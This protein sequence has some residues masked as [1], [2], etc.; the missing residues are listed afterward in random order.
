[1]D[2]ASIASKQPL[3]RFDPD[4]VESLA[5]SILE[6]DGLLKPLVLRATG[7]ESFEVVDRHLEYWAAVRAREKDPR[8][9]EMVNAYVALP[10]STE[11]IERQLAVLKRTE[12]GEEPTAAGMPPERGGYFRRA[13]HRDTENGSRL[14]H[15]QGGLRG[16][17]APDRF[18]RRH[19]E[20]TV[21]APFATGTDG[22]SFV[23]EDGGF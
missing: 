16:P 19:S 18:L 22:G 1:V 7:P 2:V 14:H 12:A 5:D 9:G 20:R 15:R 13:P 17:F 4:A 10:K 11:A 21:F 23:E 6:S 8:K 3:D